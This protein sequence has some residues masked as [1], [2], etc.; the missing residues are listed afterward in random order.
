MS[1]YY[2]MLRPSTAEQLSPTMDRF[3]APSPWPRLEGQ[4]PI[5]LP[6]MMTAGTGEDPTS[7]QNDRLHE[8][9]V[10]KPSWLAP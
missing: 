8:G 4:A 9:A 2:A 6:W 3:C 5:V 7:V 1:R 10:L